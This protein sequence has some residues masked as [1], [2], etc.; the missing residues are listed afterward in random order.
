MNVIIPLCGK[1]ERFK[2][3]Y[4]DIK[5]LIKVYGKEIIFHLLDRLDIS[6]NIDVYIIIN[7]N[8]NKTNII[9]IVNSK[10]SNIKFIDIYNQTRGSAET[11]LLGLEKVK[12]AYEKT[13]LLDG[14]SF[15][16][17][18]IISLFNNIKHNAILYFNDNDEC[19]QYSYIKFLDNKVYE[20]KEKEKISDY[21]N[22]GAYFFE[23]YNELIK[24]IKIII[25]KNK[26]HKNE[27]Y[28]STVIDEM[29]NDNKYF[30]AILIDKHNFISLG[31]PLLVDSYINKTYSFLFDLDGTL[32]I[33]D[34][35]YIKVW[36]KIL[37]KYNI[38]INENFFRD[39]IQGLNDNIFLKNF[40]NINEE[41][42]K[43][44]SK[45][46]DVLFDQYLN[47]IIL[48]KG[49]EKSM[50]KIKEYGHNICIVTNSNRKTA[51]SILEYLNLSKYIDY[52]I[53]GNECEKTKP[54]PDPY[55][56]AMKLLNTTSDRCFIFEDSKI[57]ILSA[58]NSNPKLIIGIETNNSKE[59]L[60]K[61]GVDITLSDY[62]N[63]IFDLFSYQKK[64]KI[65]LKSIIYNN[66]YKKYDIKDIIIDENKMKG[67]YI[68][69]V[70]NIIL[71]LNNGNEIK[72]IL[73]KSNIGE[74]KLSI[75]AEQLDLYN[76]ECYFYE[77]LSHYVN[78][79]I[80][81]YYATIRDDNYNIIGLLMENVTDEN[82][83]LNLNMNEQNVNIVLSVIDNLTLLHS[84]FM[85]KNLTKYFPSLKKT[86]KLTFNK[87]K[88]I[89]DNIEHFI[90]KWKFILNDKNIQILRIINKNYKF[91]EDQLS[92]GNLTLCHGDFKSPNIFYHVKN[93]NIILIDWQYIMY[94]KGVQDLIFFMIES[95]EINKIN[96]LFNLLTNYYYI[97]LQKRTEIN[98]S[99]EEYKKDITY[100]ICYF[101]MFV[102][103]WFGTI[104][105]NELN[106]KNFPFF[107]IK[108]FI[109]F[110]D[111][112]V[113]INYIDI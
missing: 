103:I 83:I 40:F 92:N 29:L 84:K 7:E 95:F 75:I 71:V 39:H 4:S 109:N 106:D 94:S 49:V 100:S 14:D 35:I 53:I 15:Y 73:K 61:Y 98:Y 2:Y 87:S 56:K 3:K 38:I 11:I 17:K 19:A 13:L 33:T 74:N 72:C 37:S 36:E 22:T 27:F 113:D 6:N 8:T 90:E 64:N 107:F 54:Y 45:L 97:Q 89:S 77:Q 57:G 9:E 63:N 30:S 112:Y 20:I 43:N 26:M 105:I 48:L 69:D 1:G 46:K 88:F 16:T 65:N 99:I 68:S 50:M 93:N 12:L 31:T 91:I 18:N 85:N 32:I 34:N 47:E 41:E 55:L 101:P 44:I 23:N 25:S 42:I 24:Y 52:I 79:N 60:Y 102:S 58:I 78:I 51:E 86:N 81:K 5:P 104:N 70:I 28:I 76:N 96:Q 111:N 59:Q 10:Y 62:N 110:I 82:I 21:A 66:I 80:P 67:G 108:K